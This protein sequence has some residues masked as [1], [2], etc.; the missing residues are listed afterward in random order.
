MKI[1]LLLLLSAITLN[2][3]LNAQEYEYWTSVYNGT[4][5]AGINKYIGRGGEVTIPSVIEG[6]EVISIGDDAFK[7]CGTIT[8]ITIPSTVINI[9]EGAFAHCSSLTNVFLPESIK[10][11]RDSSFQGCTSLQKITIPQSVINIE[12]AF[13][14]SH[15]LTKAIFLGDK[16]SIGA[17][18]FPSQTVFY[19]NSDRL[20][21]TQSNNLNVTKEIQPIINSLIVTKNNNVQTCLINIETVRGFSYKLQK[22]QDIIN[23]TDHSQFIGDDRNKYIQ[24]NLSDRSFYRLLQQ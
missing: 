18:S 14:D 11:L 15:N 22:S 3:I 2:G 12:M 5:V 16:P 21:W 23:W 13:W 4:I 17:Y 6:Y 9:G 8:S 10:T 7:N 20:G 24:D 1:L 19:Y